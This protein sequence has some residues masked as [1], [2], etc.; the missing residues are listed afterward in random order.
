MRG[1]S[2]HPEIGI[3]RQGIAPLPAH[4]VDGRQTTRLSLSVLATCAESLHPQTN[5]N[6]RKLA[7]SKC[8]SWCWHPHKCHTADLPEVCFMAAMHQ[9]RDGHKGRG[10]FRTGVLTSSTMKA[11]IG[12]RSRVP[13]IGGM[14]P[15]K[16]FKYGSHSVLHRH[17][18]HFGQLQRIKR[19]LRQPSDQAHARA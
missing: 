7:S 15:L 14:M 6:S 1:T 9:Q 5:V 18:P 8:H 16:R 11:R 19:P 10:G 12:D 2:Q 4:T 13:P 17:T 3:V